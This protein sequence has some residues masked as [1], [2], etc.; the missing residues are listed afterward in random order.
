MTT[1]SILNAKKKNSVTAF[2]KKKSCQSVDNQ[3]CF[4]DHHASAPDKCMHKGYLT[5][6]Q[7]YLT[8]GLIGINNYDLFHLEMQSI[9]VDHYWVTAITISLF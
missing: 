3:F 6:A 5:E 9:G 7:Q 8:S 1:L 4:H 2:W